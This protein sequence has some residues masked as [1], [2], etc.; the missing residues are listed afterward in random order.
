MGDNKVQKRL[1][2]ALDM[3]EKQ[4]EV[5]KSRFSF[6][7][8]LGKNTQVLSVGSWARLAKHKIDLALSRA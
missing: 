8:W 3:Y 4:E 5:W 6:R 7:E 1:V 2:E